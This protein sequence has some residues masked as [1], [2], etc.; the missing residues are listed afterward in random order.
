MPGEL[1]GLPPGQ[2]RQRSLQ[3]DVD[4]TVSQVHA[5]VGY[6]ACLL[7]C[8]SELPARS[9]SQ[10]S[11][12]VSAHGQQEDVHEAVEQA[13][14]LHCVAN[15]GCKIKRNEHLYYGAGV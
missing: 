13:V 12:Q 5:A 6:L 9:H 8:T 7:E 4:G 2:R 15:L 3:C 1:G 11:R 14:L 10:L